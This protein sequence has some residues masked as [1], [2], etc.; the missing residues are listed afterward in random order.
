MPSTACY[1]EKA[2][3]VDALLDTLS[4]HIRREVILYFESRSDRTAA[5]REEVVSHLDERIPEETPETL[6]LKLTHS[7][8]PKLAER[9]WLAYDSRSGKVRYLGH[10]RARRWLEQVVD[11]F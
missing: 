5:T 6:E 8:L 11:V 3:K 1:P 2:P 9:G 4:H 10:D 7:H